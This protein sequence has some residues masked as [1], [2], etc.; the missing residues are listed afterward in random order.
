MNGVALRS[1]REHWLRSHEW[2]DAGEV[3]AGMYLFSVLEN[4]R[5]EIQHEEM[6]QGKKGRGSKGKSGKSH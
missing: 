2:T 1:E 4:E 6:E 5:Q 3:E